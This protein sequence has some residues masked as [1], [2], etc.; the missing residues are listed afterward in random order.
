MTADT[1]A[2]PEDA[3]AKPRRKFKFPTAFTVLFFVLVLVWI[4]TFII[5]PGTYSYVSCDG[6]S[7]PTRP[8][9]WCP[10]SKGTKTWP[11]ALRELRHR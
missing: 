7:R 2:S 1:K 5:K 8:G 6:G 10:P 3:A 11:A 4:L 9:R